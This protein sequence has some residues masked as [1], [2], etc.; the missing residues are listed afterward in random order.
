MWCGMLWI[1]LCGIV[2][3]WH[4]MVWGSGVWLEVVLSRSSK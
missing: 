2:W 4:G 1:V 3:M